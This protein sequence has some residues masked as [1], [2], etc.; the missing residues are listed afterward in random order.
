MRKALDPLFVSIVGIFLS[1]ILG[2]GLFRVGI[3]TNL[4]V[5]LTLFGLGGG[6]AGYLGG[7]FV[8]RS[9]S[10]RSADRSWWLATELFGVLCASVLVILGIAIG[11]PQMMHWGILGL[12]ICMASMVEERGRVTRTIP[13]AAAVLWAIFAYLSERSFS[14]LVIGA[15]SAL[16]GVVTYF[17]WTKHFGQEKAT[18]SV[19]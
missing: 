1:V 8:G 4:A 9:G 13:W 11:V 10:D 6:T 18:N 14:W 5:G 7:I 12:L 2:V 16:S 17:G 15:L 19:K 3:Y